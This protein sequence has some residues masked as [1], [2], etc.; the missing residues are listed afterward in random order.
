MRTNRRIRPKSCATEHPEVSMSPAEPATRSWVVPLSWAAVLLDGFDLVVLGVVVP[1]LLSGH[2]WGLTP[3]T[4]AVASTFGLVGMTI[5]AMAIGTITD[6]IGRRK[7]RIS[8]GG[9]VSGVP[10]VAGGAP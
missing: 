8:A 6:V 10:G 9:A 5:G 2:V 3:G 4:V 7:A 1:I